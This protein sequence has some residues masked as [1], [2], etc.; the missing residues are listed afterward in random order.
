MNRKHTTKNHS[1]GW[2]P[3]ET[4]TMH[5]K[6]GIADW[7]LRFES[8]FRLLYGVMFGALLAVPFGVYHSTVEPYV[9]G[10][11]W[12]YSL[13]VGYVGL[14]LGLAAA[15]YSRLEKRGGMRFS[16]FL[17]LAGLLLLLVFA[18]APKDGFV[19]LVHATSF[20]AA[21]IDVDY[22]VGNWAVMGLATL[23]IFTGLTAKI[24]H[25]KQERLQT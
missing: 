12:G 1:R 4:T 3:K 13:P 19:N 18:F 11:L 15:F 2:L 6:L 16:R 22:A 7:F 5:Q 23:S 9:A 24:S 17:M 20:S 10:V 25:K 8:V 14:A 21:K